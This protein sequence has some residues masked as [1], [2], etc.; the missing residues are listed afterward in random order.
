LD[1]V[2]DALATGRA[3]RVLSFIDNFTRECHAI[4]ADASLACQRVTRVLD[5]VIARRGSPKV[6]R[7][8][9]ARNLLRGTFRSWCIER[10]IATN[11]IQPGKPMQKGHI[12]K[13]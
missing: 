11:Y 12:E 9:M 2:R 13:L 3:L 7:W 6:L 10:K 4:E 1:F 5:D 8:T